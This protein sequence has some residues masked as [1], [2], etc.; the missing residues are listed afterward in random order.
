MSMLEQDGLSGQE[1][2]HGLMNIA[3][4]ELDSTLYGFL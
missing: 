3:A 2:A 1:R 4:M